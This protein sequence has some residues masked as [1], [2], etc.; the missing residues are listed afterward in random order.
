VTA[1]KNAP[2]CSAGHWQSPY[3]TTVTSE[4]SGRSKRVRSVPVRVDKLL[5][6]V[7]LATHD[8]T[9]R[10]K[11][12]VASALLFRRHAQHK[13]FEPNRRA[14]WLELFFDLIFVVAIGDVTHILNHTHE[15]HLAPLRFW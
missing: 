7:L 8:D 3:S 10:A 6:S 15:G 13:Y 11:R 2:A 5:V 14:T 1:E 4:P 9:V 12:P